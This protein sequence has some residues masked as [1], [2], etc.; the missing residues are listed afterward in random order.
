[1]DQIENIRTSEVIDNEMDKKCAPGTTFKNGSC[2]SLNILIEMANAYNAQSGG[3]PIKLYPSYEMLNPAKYKKYLLKEFKKRQTK[4]SSQQ[5]WIEQGFVDRLNEKVQEELR[6]YTFRPEGPQG[7]FEWLNTIHIND[8]MEQYEKQ[9]SDFKFLGAVPIDFDNLKVLGIKDLNFN[10]LMKEGKT[11][12][13]IIFNSHEHTMPGEHWTSLFANLKEGKIYYSDSY[14]T[15]PE[16]RIRKLIRRIAKF[17]QSGLGIINPIADYNNVRNQYGGSEC[18]V[19]SINFILRMLRGETFNE[20]KS[21]KVPDKIINE[22][23]SLYFN[24]VNHVS[25]PDSIC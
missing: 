4:C 23:R 15:R 1:M 9:Y 10:D 7:K 3:N 18:G 6:K 17:C 21:K 8:V 2:I 13:G 5:C 22:C 14:G 24:N 11:K 19:Y 25:T 16:M 20:V 12:L